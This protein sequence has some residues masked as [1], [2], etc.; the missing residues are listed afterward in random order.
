VPSFFEKPIRL[1]VI[2]DTH[3][4]DRIRRFPEGFLESLIKAE[5]D[6]IFH[7]GD[8]SSWKVINALEEIAPVS[9]VQGNRDWFFRMDVPPHLKCTLHGVRI[10]LAHGHG[11]IP[12]YLADKVAAI[13]KGYRFKRYQRPL[14]RA[15][16][17]ADLIIFG[18]VHRQVSKW[19]NNQLFF[20]PGSVFP[21]SY[22]HYSPQYGVI[23]IQPD[24][25]IQTEFHTL[26]K[27]NP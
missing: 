2:A 12:L 10:V 24:G 22:N 14:A 18:H 20:N 13:L 9:A 6:R 5:V 17:D 8:I 21:C 19:V 27:A 23:T 25:K 7:A 16:P 11:S 26:R 15:F 3:I 4:P 1:G